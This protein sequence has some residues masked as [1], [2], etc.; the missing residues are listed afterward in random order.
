MKSI[1]LYTSKSPT[2]NN[3]PINLE[4]GSVIYIRH[5]IVDYATDEALNIASP[6]GDETVI[7]AIPH[8]CENDKTLAT[9]GVAMR[10]NEAGK[11]ST[12]E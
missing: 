2:A 6:M 5:E 10:S 7:N 9:G 12:L 4:D 11:L 1:I 8:P 3:Q